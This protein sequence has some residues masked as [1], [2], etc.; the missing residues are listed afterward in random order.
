MRRWYL[1]KI[2]EYTEDSL[3]YYAHA[4]QV[5]HPGVEYRGGEI[6]VDGN[7]TPTETALLVLVGGVDHRAFAS[8]PDLIPLPDWPTDGKVEGIAT[9]RKLA[10]RNRIRDELGESESAVAARWDNPGNYRDV[11]NEYGRRNNAE[12]DVNNFDLTDL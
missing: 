7:G 4:L 5:N 2:R 9:P 12:F 11:L 10:V 3:T 8:D 6:K 1:S